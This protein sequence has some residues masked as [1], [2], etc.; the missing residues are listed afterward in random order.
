M[1]A[2]DDVMAVVDSNLR[3][4]GTKNLRIVDAS[5]FPHI[6]GLFVVTAIYMLSEKASDMIL[7]D[8]PV[9]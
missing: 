9:A 7:A 6:P 4:R 8:A 3:V 2:Q 5:V 1:G